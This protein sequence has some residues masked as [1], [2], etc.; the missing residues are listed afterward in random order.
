MKSSA[1]PYAF[2]R[3][4]TNFEKELRYDNVKTRNTENY[5]KTRTLRNMTAA[6]VGGIRKGEQVTLT[7]NHERQ[8][9]LYCKL[10][11]KQNAKVASSK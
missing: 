3:L 9:K 5:R 6:K 7:W 2:D 11:K 8:G 10:R 4:L 1:A